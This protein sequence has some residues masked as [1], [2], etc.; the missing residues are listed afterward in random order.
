MGTDIKKEK[1]DTKKSIKRA[2]ALRNKKSLWAIRIRDKEYTWSNKIERVTLIR[3]RLPYEAIELLS[4]RTELSIKEV[5]SIFDLPQ[6]T[7]NKKKREN[8]LLSGRDSEVVLLLTELLD[9]GIEVF[10]N[11]KEKFNRWLKKPNYSLGG[12]KPETLFDTVTGIQEVKNALNR[13]EYGN[14]A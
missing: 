1:F 12:I 7:Y 11:E 14:M 9:F 8:G 5:L 3:D 6:T 4:A 13:L 2:R 10:N